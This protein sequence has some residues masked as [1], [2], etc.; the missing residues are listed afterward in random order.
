LRN[1][2]SD[3]IRRF[4]KAVLGNRH[5]LE[6][7]RAIAEETKGRVSARRLARELGLADSLV[8]P[9]LKRLSALGLLRPLPKR[10]AELF[11]ERRQ[12]KFWTAMT[13]IHDDATS[14][15]TVRRRR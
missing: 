4:S 13:D 1:P 8:Q 6:I 14:I 7:A 12:F 5:R 9:E 10:G 3:P 2:N 11:Y 15:A